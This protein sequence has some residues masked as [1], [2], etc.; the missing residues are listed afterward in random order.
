M[1][2]PQ[3]DAADR[4][5]A[6]RRS[7]AVAAGTRA[8]L[9][10]AARTLF[11][12]RGVDAVSTRQIAEAAGVSHGLVRHHFG[13]KRGVW[14]A[15]V[16]AADAEF[17]SILKPL[18]DA[19]TGTDPEGPCEPDTSAFIEGFIRACARQPDIA[20]LLV[21]EGSVQNDRL[22]YILESLAGARAAVA[23]VAA[24]LRACG[25]LPDVND[26][27]FLL[28][29]LSAGMLPFGLP[30]L[31]QGVLGRPLSPE[32]HARVL[33]AALFSGESGRRPSVQLDGDSS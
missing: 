8:G 18:G 5:A 15:V 33:L 21:H 29:L 4:P 27:E 23:P 7:D 12:Q 9:V 32:R 13:S 22:D 16:D 19:F 11:A 31:A 30:A 3:P 24:R 25:A 14:R 1:T 28:L 26:D 20:Q 6:G 17:A 10:A 2:S